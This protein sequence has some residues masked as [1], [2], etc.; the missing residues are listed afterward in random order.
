MA[1]DQRSS[2]PEQS[3]ASWIAAAC[4]LGMSVRLLRRGG[5]EAYIVTVLRYF[6]IELGV[7]RLQDFP[8]GWE[9]VVVGCNVRVVNTSR[10]L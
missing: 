8:N 9:Y 7:R 1:E 6:P 5:V 2:I 3:P 10:L 4:C